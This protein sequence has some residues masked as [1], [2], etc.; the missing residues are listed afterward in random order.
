MDHTVALWNNCRCRLQL[1]TSSPVLLDTMTDWYWVCYSLPAGRQWQWHWQWWWSLLF[2]ASALPQ[3]RGLWLH[4]VT[5]ISPSM[6]W[7]LSPGRRPRSPRSGETDCC[8]HCVL[9]WDDS[10]TWTENVSGTVITKKNKGQSNL[11]IVASNPLFFPLVPVTSTYGGLGLPFN[12]TFFVPQQS[13]LR[14]GTRSSQQILHGAGAWQ[15]DRHTTLRERRSQFFEPLMHSM[16]TKIIASV[17]SPVYFRIHVE[18]S[19]K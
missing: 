7:S 19:A 8:F 18:Q 11:P 13:S 16:G 4:P 15:T 6:I 3:L 12:I 17:R 5:Y 10:S 9:V 2:T 1:P 14:S